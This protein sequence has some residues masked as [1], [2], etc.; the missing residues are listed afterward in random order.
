MEPAEGS[1]TNFILLGDAAFGGVMDLLSG[2][3]Y[4]YPTGQQHDRGSD[5]VR[6]S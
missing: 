5:T 2:L 6:D 3:D 4:A 1:H